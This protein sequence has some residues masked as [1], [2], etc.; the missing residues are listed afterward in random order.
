VSVS[1]ASSSLKR[2]ISTS[3]ANWLDWI[4]SMSLFAAV[5]PL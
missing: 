5:V 2:E 4:S 3:L 1:I